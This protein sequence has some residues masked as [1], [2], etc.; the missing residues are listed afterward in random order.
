MGSKSLRNSEG[1]LTAKSKCFGGTPMGT[2]RFDNLFGQIV[3]FGVTTGLSA[4][5]SLILPIVLHELGGL[6]ERIAVAIGFVAAFCANTIL[7]PRFVFRSTQGWKRETSVY[8]LSSAGF[9]LAEY[10]VFLVLLDIFGID[11]RVSVVIVLAV[12]SLSKFFFYRFMF[13]EKTGLRS[14]RRN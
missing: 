3:R 7:V 6:D 1:S 14:P 4:I 12:S 13:A 9:R 11:Y 5:L 8:V 2:G 10:L